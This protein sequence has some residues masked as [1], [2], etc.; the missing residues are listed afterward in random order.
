V[1]LG[2]SIEDFICSPEAGLNIEEA[3]RGGTLHA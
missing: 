2:E 3:V 1:E